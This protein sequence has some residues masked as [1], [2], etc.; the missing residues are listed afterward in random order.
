MHP[1]R[2]APALP[3]VFRRFALPALLLLALCLTAFQPPPP[4]GTGSGSVTVQ[5][6]SVEGMPRSGVTV[7]FLDE[8]HFQPYAACTTDL[9]G[10]CLLTI[11]SAP[12][13][14]EM[15]RGVVDVGAGRGVSRYQ[16][17]MFLSG[18]HIKVVLTLSENGELVRGADVLAT[19][20]PNLTPTLIHPQDAV[21]TL[22]AAALEP[23]A[24]PSPGIVLTVAEAHTRMTATAV[25]RT[26]LTPATT[27][28][29]TSTPRVGVAVVV[30]ASPVP[31]VVGAEATGHTGASATPAASMPTLLQ[32]VAGGILVVVVGA[33]VVVWLESRHRRTAGGRP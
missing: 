11:E 1:L 15:V 33:G 28:T 29:I 20:D 25:A 22:T 10:A 7:H 24:T 16:D 32:L 2:P 8:W 14:G 3:T 30:N 9:T 26:T 21:A 5:V 27:P 18:D 12:A 23:L 6:R 4:D 19:R 31:T 17:A 13:V